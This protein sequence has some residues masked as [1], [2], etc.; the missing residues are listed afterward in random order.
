MPLT[1]DELSTFS[2]KGLVIKRGFVPAHLVD[3]AAALV[4]DWYRTD[5]DQHRLVEYTQRTFAP[6]LGD[7]PDLLALFAHSGVARLAAELVGD[8]APVGTTQIQIRVP[9]REL[10]RAQPEKAMHVDGVACPHLDPAELRTFSLLIGVVLS[11]VS[12]PSG[13][14]LRYVAGGHLRMADWFRTQWSRG[15]TAQVPP[16]IDVEQGTTLLGKP[17][18]VLLMHHLVPHAVGRNLTATPR[19]MA[20]FRVS[21]VHHASRRLDALRDPW[22][23]FPPLTAPAR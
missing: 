16:H 4:T 17:G 7:H 13:G 19:I 1:A 12:D 3:R 22:L 11:D 5:M 18:D 20:Y 10:D 8:L 21:H 6:Q 9:E 23:D 14:A 15:I 2:T